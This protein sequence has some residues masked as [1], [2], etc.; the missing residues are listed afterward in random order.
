MGDGGTPLTLALSQGEREGLDLP[1]GRSDVRPLP[2]G[3]GRPAGRVRVVP[4]TS[5]PAPKDV[6]N[7]PVSLLLRTMFWTR[8][9]GH[10]DAL[11]SGRRP[12]RGPARFA[13]AVF[14]RWIKGSE[15]RQIQRQPGPRLDSPRVIASSG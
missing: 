6:R 5:Y 3:R 15:A 10:L 14:P 1:E 4:R 11:S 13:A 2:A 8:A 12:P 9:S 7:D